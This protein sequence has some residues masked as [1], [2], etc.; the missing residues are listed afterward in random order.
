[1]EL[2]ISIHEGYV[3]SSSHVANPSFSH[4]NPRR[5]FD[6][7]GCGDGASRLTTYIDSHNR[8]IVAK[9]QST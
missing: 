8:A 6:P 9:K 1:M 2:F 3:F 4:G 7:L 5:S